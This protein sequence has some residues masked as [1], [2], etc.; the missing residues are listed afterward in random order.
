[1]AGTATK[2]FYCYKDV[3]SNEYG[4]TIGNLGVDHAPKTSPKWCPKRVKE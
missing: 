4:E 3:D 2:D 1:M